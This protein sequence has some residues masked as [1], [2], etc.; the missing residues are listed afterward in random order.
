MKIFSFDGGGVLG[1]G[2]ASFLWK[3][4]RDSYTLSRKHDVFA[5]TSAG[6]I[7]AAGG[8]CGLSWSEIYYLFRKHLPTI[9]AHPPLSWRLDPRKPKFQGIGLETALRAV[10]G[11]KRM[12]DLKFPLFIVSYDTK[13]GIP[14]VYDNSDAT[15]IWEAV[16]NSCSAPTYFPPRNGMVDGGLVANSPAMVAVAGCVNKLRVS[17]QDLSILSFGTGGEYWRDPKVGTNT[18]AMGWAKFLLSSPTRGNEMLGEFQARTIL[19]GRYLR[20]EPMLQKD[21]RMDD[22]S[23]VDEYSN[24]WAGFFVAMRDE[25]NKFIA[26][27]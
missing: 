9:F 25:L 7:I 26:E 15:P 16:A 10:F 21:F 6:S 24:I 3:W 5:G 18:S 27:G 20:I 17:T 11:D 22:L 19:D 23:I 12:C 13:L 1:I 2:P 14:K 8:A 4:E